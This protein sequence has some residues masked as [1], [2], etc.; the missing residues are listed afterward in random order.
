[1]AYA[2]SL[3]NVALV[4]SLIGAHAWYITK[5]NRDGSTLKGAERPIPVEVK[6]VEVMPGSC[7]AC[8][9]GVSEQVLACKFRTVSQQ[10]NDTPLVV[11]GA[12]TASRP[13][14]ATLAP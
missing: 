12:W 3:K 8:H 11:A 9:T 1:M 5:T 2:L 10:E 13:A 6:P 7:S 4:A 14:S